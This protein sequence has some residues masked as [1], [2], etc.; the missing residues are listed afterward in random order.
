MFN[1]LRE[2]PK[3]MLLMEEPGNT[4]G[5]IGMQQ[6][7]TIWTTCQT[8]NNLALG[9]LGGIHAR[10]AKCFTIPTSSRVFLDEVGIVKRYYAT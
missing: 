5:Q 2:E 1:G 8:V 7:K 3:F 6:Q 9:S 10:R 4:S